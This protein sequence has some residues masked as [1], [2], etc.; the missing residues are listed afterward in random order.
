MVGEAPGREE[1]RLGR[2]FVGSA[3]KILDDAL[4]RSGLKRK[5]IFLTSILKCRPPQ[6]RNPKA[7]EIVACR[8]Y[9]VRQIEAISPNVVVAL[10][11]FGFKGLTGT[12]PK[13]A[14]MRGRRLEFEGIPVV[15]TYHPAAVLRNRRLM[16][17]FV[18]DLKRAKSLGEGSGGRA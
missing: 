6:N 8:P 5:D 10:G 7:S 18:N 16:R 14:D 4:A 9:L 3:G 15:L 13:I 2:P 17:K 12:T 11:G 1:D